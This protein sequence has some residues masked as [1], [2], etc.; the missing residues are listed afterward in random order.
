LDL[1]DTLKQGAVDWVESLRPPFM[2]LLDAISGRFGLR[3]R[4]AIVEATPEAMFLGWDK[5]AEKQSRL[6]LL[7]AELLGI[8]TKEVLEAARRAKRDNFAGGGAGGGGDFGGNPLGLDDFMKDFDKALDK[9]DKLRERHDKA[10]GRHAAFDMTNT[11]DPNYADKAGKVSMVG[12]EANWNKLAESLAGGGSMQNLTEQI[13]ENT[14]VGNE[15]AMATRD[16]TQKIADGMDALQNL[17]R[18]A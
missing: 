7:K 11:A 12:F 18:L 2:A 6:D 10:A 15:V 3:L 9:A 1:W 5:G 4:M 17:G 13:K 16:N 8:D 14:A